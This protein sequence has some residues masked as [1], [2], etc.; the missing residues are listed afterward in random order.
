MKN[1]SA[2]Q[3]FSAIQRIFNEFDNINPEEETED[4]CNDKTRLT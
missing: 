2:E 3:I 4:E 1:Y